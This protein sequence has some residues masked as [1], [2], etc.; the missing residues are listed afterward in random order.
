MQTPSSTGTW[1][2][3]PPRYSRYIRGVVGFLLFLLLQLPAYS[4]SSLSGLQECSKASNASVCADLFGV[5][6]NLISFPSSSNVIP[7]PNSSVQVVGRV[8]SQAKTVANLNVGG[9][10]NSKAGMSVAAAG[11]AGVGAAS[12]W[13]ISADRLDSLRGEAYHKYMDTFQAANYAAFDAIP[14]TTSG[15]SYGFSSKT[16]VKDVPGIYRLSGILNSPPGRSY[17]SPSLDAD[18]IVEVVEYVPWSPGYDGRYV[19]GYRAGLVVGIYH[20]PTSSV[21]SSYTLSLITPTFPQDFDALS[22]EQKNVA[23]D[24]LTAAQLAGALKGQNV[25]LPAG[26]DRFDL[27]P[28]AGVEAYGPQVLTPTD[29]AA[30]NPADADGATDKAPPLRGDLD[31]DGIVDLDLNGD[32]VVDAADQALAEQERANEEKQKQDEEEQEKDLDDDLQESVP[33]PSV[34]EGSSQVLPY[35][36]CKLKSKFPFDFVGSVLNPPSQAP[37]CPEFEFYGQSLELCWLN[38]MF[39]AIKW[40]VWISFSI[41]GVL[42]L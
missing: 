38:T 8:G 15:S 32:G 40:A 27:N 3:L 18:M 4:Q 26:Y 29:A 33:E 21:R 42:N 24:L 14:L 2:V 22:P 36:V 12:L 5:K 1:A 35:A 34:C 16:I 39:T 7:F 6:S 28:G 9:L 13:G 31:G 30:G 23:V 41:N 19:T 20:A 17:T 25:N 37:S 11:L 10:I